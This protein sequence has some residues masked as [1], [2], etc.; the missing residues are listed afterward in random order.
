MV[1]ISLHQ[2]LELQQATQ[3]LQAQVPSRLLWSVPLLQ[4]LVLLPAAEAGLASTV[5]FTLSIIQIYQKKV[6]L[7]SLF[8][9]QISILTTKNHY[10]IVLPN[11]SY[12]PLFVNQSINHLFDSS[13][14]VYIFYTVSSSVPL[15]ALCNLGLISIQEKQT[16]V[17]S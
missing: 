8:H 11:Q 16:N 12:I 15:K 6:S 2:V 7:F 17:C 10:S 4:V 14:Q 3:E 13:W 5:S 1:P 9:C